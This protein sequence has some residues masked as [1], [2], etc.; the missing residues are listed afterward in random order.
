MPPKG[1][2]PSTGASNSEGAPS[3][4]FERVNLRVAKPLIEAVRDAVV[5]LSGPPVR[6]TFAAFVQEAFRRELERLKAKYTG[7][8]PFPRRKSG[9][10]P[11]R[12]IGS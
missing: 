5:H 4:E 6:L 11:G 1:K 3:P 2:K 12:P 10:R 7:G 8:K 9:P